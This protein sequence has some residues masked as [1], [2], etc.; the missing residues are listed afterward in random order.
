MS[1]MSA[2]ST[3]LDDYCREVKR[4]REV[5]AELVDRL[6]MSVTA[7]DDWLKTYAYDDCDAT[8][9]SESRKRIWKKGGTVAYIAG[10]Q[11]LNR[12]AIAKAER[13]R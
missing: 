13:L 11:E 1:E 10:V 6:N 2:I 3:M 4:L 7:I 9:V 12:E 8:S 5:N